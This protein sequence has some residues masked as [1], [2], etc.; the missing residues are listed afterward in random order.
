MS[1]SVSQTLNHINENNY[2]DD[3]TVTDIPKGHFAAVTNISISAGETTRSVTVDLL[4]LE[5]SDGGTQTV[6]T[7]LYVRQQD[8]TAV[9]AIVKE[10]GK[11]VAE[12][13]TSYS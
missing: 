5:Q 8:E 7:G 10:N 12:N 2:D 11:E 6:N 9:K 4:P 13:T 3:I 1:I